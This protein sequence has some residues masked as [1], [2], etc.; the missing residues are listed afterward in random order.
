MSVRQVRNRKIFIMIA[1]SLFLLFV[2]F[3]QINA[4]FIGAFYNKTI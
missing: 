3:R 4:F 1:L 2:H